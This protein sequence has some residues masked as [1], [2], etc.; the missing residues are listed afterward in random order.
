SRLHPAL[1]NGGSGFPWL[2]R[3][4]LPPLDSLRPD[5][6][7]A[8]LALKYNGLVDTGWPSYPG[9]SYPPTYLGSSLPACPTAAHLASAHSTSSSH[10]DQQDAHAAASS[11]HLS[12]LAEAINSSDHSLMLNK[13]LL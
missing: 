13:D 6:L 10:R 11:T 3:P 9:A 2:G 4:F 7:A 8:S 1:T 5:P 12:L